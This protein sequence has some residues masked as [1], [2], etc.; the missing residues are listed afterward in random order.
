VTASEQLYKLADRAK[1]AEES[2]ESAKNKTQAE[3]TAQVQQ[4]R[5]SSQRRAAERKDGAADAE[6]RAS[7]WWT[8][9]QENWNSHVAKIRQNVDDTK[10]DLDVK[11]AERRAESAEA[12][13]EAAVDFAYAAL[14]EAEYAVLDAALARVEADETA[15]VR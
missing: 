3:L 10:A 7:T 12:D 1:N 6:A 11:R 13:A 9:V 5:Q 15:A 8:D 14:E 4:A 2:V